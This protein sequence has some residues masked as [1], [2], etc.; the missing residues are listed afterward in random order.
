VDHRA[1]KTCENPEQLGQRGTVKGAAGPVRQGHDRERVGDGPPGTGFLHLQRR[2]QKFPGRGHRGTAARRP[3]ERAGKDQTRCT[4]TRR[5]APGGVARGPSPGVGE[6]QLGIGSPTRQTEDR[7]RF[8]ESDGLAPSHRLLISGDLRRDG[9]GEAQP[10]GDNVPGDLLQPV[11]H[12]RVEVP[13]GFQKAE[14]DDRR[15]CHDDNIDETTVRETA[16]TLLLAF[17][18]AL[19]ISLAALVLRALTASGALAATIVG[20][21]IGA[22]SGWPGLTM[23]GVFF[24]GSSLISR[25]AP[26]VGISLDA[27]GSQRDWAQVVANGGAAAAGAWHPEAALWIVAAALGAAAADTW[28][29]SSGG[30]SRGWPRQILTRVRVPPGT[31]G[32][33]TW[34]GSLGAL[35]GAASVGAAGLIVGQDRLLFPLAVGMG[36]LGMLLDSLL[37]ASVQGRYHCDGCDKDTERHRHRCGRIARPAGGVP[38]ITNDV[39]NAM[40]TGAAAL[41]GWSAWIWW[42]GSVR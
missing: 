2:G 13:Q 34:L 37:G 40:A 36:M 20:T 25:V 14:R 30:W 22:G 33:M 1:F 16:M 39:V 15:N 32:G 19:A 21:A 3:P 8:L 7:D 26:D 4:K 18:L 17:L 23:L 35:A 42:S 31:S 24:V 6:D 12:G 41:L 9:S 5:S 38:W 10:L 27:K 11:F 28:A 29:T